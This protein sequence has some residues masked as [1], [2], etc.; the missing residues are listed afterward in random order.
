[1]PETSTHQSTALLVMDMQNAIVERFAAAPVL[2]RAVA[3]AAAAR[4]NGVPVIFVRV[5]FRPGHPEVSPRNKAF[6][7]LTSRRRG[8]DGGAGAAGARGRLTCRGIGAPRT[9]G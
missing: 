1:V 5:G 7:A 8:V 9:R 6:A 3:A 2:E 4:A